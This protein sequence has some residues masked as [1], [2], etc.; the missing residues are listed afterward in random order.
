[1]NEIKIKCPTCGK[2][3]RL[4]ETPNVDAVSFT[5]PVCKERH[6]VG[7]CQRYNPA[8]Q[9]SASGGDET[10]YG[11]APSLRQTGDET[12]IGATLYKLLAGETPPDASMLVSDNKLVENDLR[13]KGVSEY[14]LDTVEAAMKPSIN[15]RIQT[16]RDF[17]ESLNGNSDKESTIVADL[18]A[19]PIPT[20]TTSANDN[21]K[22]KD[23]N[24]ENADGKKNKSQKILYAFVAVLVVGLCALG[25][26]SKSGAEQKS[27]VQ[28]EQQEISFSNGVLKY[29]G[30]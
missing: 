4:A 28:P 22:V 15:E 8:P 10:R 17:Q 7:D 18:E 14:I 29:R 20:S 26:L 30:G 19:E 25:I 1:M 9:P 27:G 12:R 13:A 3:L 6:V 5:C 2:A 24:G 23:F 11:G 16:V 21:D